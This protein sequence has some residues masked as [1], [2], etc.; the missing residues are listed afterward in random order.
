M[1]V[2]II[3]LADIKDID[4]LT[5]IIKKYREFYGVLPADT[6]PIRNFIGERIAKSES[7]IFIAVNEKTNTIVGFVQL[8]PSFSTVSLKP[9]WMLNDFYVEE[10]ERKKGVGAML[11]NA[12]VAHF[13]GKAKG[14]ILVTAKTNEE[15]K[16]FYTKHGWKT[17]VYD[18]YTYTY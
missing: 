4:R 15:A 13:S 7:K 11:M 14:F 2:P 9:Q 6:L 10:A 16:R 17:D 5:E 3:R 12:V 8:Y 1:H 18:F